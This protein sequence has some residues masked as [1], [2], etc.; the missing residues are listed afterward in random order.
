MEEV[1][2]GVPSRPPDRFP[3]GRR[4]RGGGESR[5][6]APLTAGDRPLGSGPVALDLDAG[7]DEPVAV[8]IGAATEE[9]AGGRERKER[10]SGPARQRRQRR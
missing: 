8:A 9:W 4:T 7:A 3:R 10:A 6:F 5:R 2:K 1:G